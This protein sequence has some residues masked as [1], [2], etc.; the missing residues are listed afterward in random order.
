MEQKRL[1]QDTNT[2]EARDVREHQEKDTAQN[3]DLLKLQQLLE[4]KVKTNKKS[5]HNL[6]KKKL[7]TESEVEKWVKKYDSEMEEKET[8]IEAITVGV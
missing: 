7:K 6:R 3:E 8:K 2:N 4:D 1:E 5:E